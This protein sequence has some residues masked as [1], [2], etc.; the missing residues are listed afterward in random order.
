MNLRGSGQ[1]LYDNALGGKAYGAVVTDDYGANIKNVQDAFSNLMSAAGAPSV[2]DAIWGL[3][4]LADAINALAAV[5]VAHPEAMR[6]VGDGAMIASGLAVI[7]GAIVSF[8]GVIALSRLA[9]AGAGWIGGGAAVAAAGATT[10][11]VASATG[12]GGYSAWKAAQQVSETKS[13]WGRLLGGAGDAAGRLAGPLG[14][15]L[16]LRDIGELANPTTPLGAPYRLDTVSP[17][18]R[19]K[20]ER[21]TRSQ[22]DLHQGADMEAA[23]GRAM[24]SLPPPVVNTKVDVSVTLDGRAIAAAVSSKITTDNRTVS[25]P[26]NFDG[27]ASWAPPEMP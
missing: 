26:S 11:G 27:R 2:K 22:R 14:L 16:L 12:L 9:L 7:G 8:A 25:T 5:A 10:A 23:R 1:T 13:L 17:D 6:I 4:G 21:S 24:M 19:E 20:F 15:A 3:H 18:W